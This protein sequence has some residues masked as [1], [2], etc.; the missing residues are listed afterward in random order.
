M[1]NAALLSNN[2]GTAV[3]QVAARVR[4][5]VAEV[6]SRGG[7]GSGTL[8]SADGTVITN[9]HVVGGDKA[10]VTL[11]DGRSYDG[12]VVARD[13]R[14]DLAALRIDGQDLPA[15]AL[16]DARDLRTG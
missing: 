2:I 5:S 16:G 7:S 13:P 12:R 10:R 8:W 9:H 14:N 6:R 15:A 11:E 1:L 4:A 3:A